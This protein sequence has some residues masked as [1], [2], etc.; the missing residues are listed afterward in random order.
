[1][2]LIL[3]KKINN[4]PLESFEVIDNVVQIDFCNMQQLG[5]EISDSSWNF[6]SIFTKENNVLKKQ[7]VKLE[8]IWQF[9][10]VVNKG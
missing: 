2:K 1:M 9:S 4:V 7:I 6:V 5:D 8:D 10:L 3:V